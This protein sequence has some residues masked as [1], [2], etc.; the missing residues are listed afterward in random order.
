MLEKSKEK[1]ETLLDKAYVLFGLKLNIK[2]AFDLSGSYIIGQCKKT[3]DGYTIRLHEPLL[4]KYNMIYL[5]D[6]LS[7]EVAHAIQMELYQYKTKPHGVEWKS[8]LSKLEN[9]PYNIKQRPQY[10]IKTVCSKKRYSYTCK[11]KTVHELSLVRHNRIKR[12]I[13]YICKNC[14]DFLIEAV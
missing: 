10:D 1:L 9:A 13:K 3:I 2:L 7:H 6:V 12:G 11:C 14:K 4:N 8:I 5:N